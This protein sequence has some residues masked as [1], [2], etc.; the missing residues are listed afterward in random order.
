M[1]TISLFCYLAIQLR[2]VESSAANQ[3]RGT[4]T[5]DPRPTNCSLLLLILTS[6]YLLTTAAFFGKLIIL[7]GLCCI[8]F[9]KSNLIC[10]LSQ[11]SGLVLVA[12]AILTAI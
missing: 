1:G 11:L 12:S 8:A 4:K 9:H 7:S 2:F 5:Q 10:M 3:E 6:I